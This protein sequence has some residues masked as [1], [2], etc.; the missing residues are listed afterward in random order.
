MV[1]RDDVLD[2]RAHHLLGMIEAHAVRHAR[3]AVMP[4]HHERV[5]PERGHHLDIVLR[6][7][8]ERIVGVIR[9]ARRL[10]GVAVTAQVGRHHGE[11]LREARRELVPRQMRERV[12]VQQQQGGTIAPM[13]RHDPRAGG[14]DL[15]AGE[16]VEQHGGRLLVEPSP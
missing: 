14:L 8:A 6:H 10:L 3:P 7:R 5:E 16:A 12:A 15:A 2:R 11:L 13:H 4:C 1:L 9:L